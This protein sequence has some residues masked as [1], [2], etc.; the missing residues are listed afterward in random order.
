MSIPLRGQG[1]PLPVGFPYDGQWI[2][3]PRMFLVVSEDD[4]TTDPTARFT[5]H[6]SQTDDDWSFGFD[7][8]QLAAALGIEVHEILQANRERR[9]NLEMIEADT[10]G[11]EGFTAK[12]YTFS[13][14]D[15]VGSLTIATPTFSGTG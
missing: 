5:T 1:N 9:L 15:K 12:R 13:V 4:T 6:I 3:E 8:V 11:G 10:P 2:L 14:G 7:A